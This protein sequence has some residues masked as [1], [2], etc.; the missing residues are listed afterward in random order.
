MII[1]KFP[2]FNF[3][4]AGIFCFV[5]MFIIQGTEKKKNEPQNLVRKVE[6]I[7]NEKQVYA[8]EILHLQTS[9]IEKGTSVL[10]FIKDSLFFWSDNSASIPSDFTQ[11]KVSEEPV[12]LRLKNGWYMVQGKKSGNYSMYV[13]ILIRQEYPFENDY[14]KNAFPEYFGLPQSTEVTTEKA[15]FPVYLP[16][17]KYA[18]NLSFP[19][20]CRSTS[21]ISTII[22]ILFLLSYLFLTAFLYRFYKNI[23]KRFTWKYFLLFGITLDLLFLRGLQFYLAFPSFLYQSDLFGP[24]FYSSSFLLPSL[25]D[26]L[27]NSTLLLALACIYYLEWPD[28]KHEKMSNGRNRL[29][30]PFLTSL[31]ALAALAGAVFF[32]REFIINSVIPLNLQDISSLIPYSG[33][34][35]FIIWTL[36]TSILLFFWKPLNRAIPGRIIRIKPTINIRISLVA[37]IV[38]SFISMLIINHANNYKEKEKRKILAIKLATK[39]NPITEIIFS[40]MEKKILTD[41]TVIR[42]AHEAGTGQRG[43]QF[44][45]NYLKTFYFTN[46]WNK[47]NIQITQCTENKRLQVQ[48]Q[49]Y[50]I[51]CL[52][53]FQNIIKEFGEN[54]SSKNLHFLDYGY[55]KENYLAVIQLKPDHPDMKNGITSIFIELNSKY[56]FKDLGYPELLIDRKLIE[57]PDISEY[58]YAF[59]QNGNMQYCA[60][61]FPYNHSLRLFENSMTKGPFFNYSGANHYYYPLSKSTVLI[62]SRKQPNLLTT[63]SPFAYLFLFF[64]LSSLILFF[65]L[66]HSF[67]KAISIKTLRDRLQISIIGMLFLSFLVLGLVIVVY[68]IRL[69][70]EKNDDYLRERA[71]SVQV[72]LQYKFGSADNGFL[73]N[74]SVLE[75]QLIKMSNI[76]FSDIN[77]Y[78][79]TGTLI[80]SSRP[81]VFD[82]GL[83]SDRM[84]AEAFNQLKSGGQ[85]LYIHEEK[86]GEHYYSSAYLPF[87]NN[88]NELQ[89]FVNLPYFTRQDDLKKEISTFLVAF[90]NIYV[91]LFILGVFIAFIVAKYIASPLRLLAIK[92]AD[93]KLGMPNER[94]EW[95]RKDEIGQ[96]VSQYN[97]MVAE[98]GE[99]A[100][101]LAASEREGAWREMARQV[102][103]E[104]KNPL[105]PM[106]L[107]VQHL[108]RAWSDSAPGWDMRLDR[109]TRTITE[110]IDALATIATEFSDFAKMPLPQNEKLNLAEV[111][112]SIIFLYKDITRF[113]VDISIQEAFIWADRKQLLR[114]FTNL[115]NNAIEA[116]AGNPDGRIHVTLEKGNGN[117]FIKI[118]DN[119]KGIPVEQTE[120]VFQPNFT[121]KSGGMGLGLAIVKAILKGVDGTIRVES[122][123]GKGATFIIGIAMFQDGINIE[124]KDE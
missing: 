41:T 104:I 20:N 30:Y 3:L 9:R 61:K 99:S 12:F 62:I 16:D 105:T 124:S 27:I 91:L 89:G 48:P 18:F 79:S 10:M 84:N 57:V 44:L 46:Y 114:V 86:I 50:L 101:K 13:F 109:F 60:G 54:T 49:G 47:F 32:I 45:E 40:Q 68:I 103:H 53:Y 39:R 8:R 1:R 22:L 69:N 23:S 29:L 90:I 11:Q 75:N 15:G 116:I 5:L 107:S 94:I 95:Q 113:S 2:G 64:G 67:Y 14:L 122:E 115:F 26:L 4:L 85:S 121:T 77:I 118:Q 74:V 70:N 42:L 106:K 102:A 55:G 108:Q 76:F 43:D 87:F 80:A 111:L 92:M 63:I 112:H 82:E 96:L 65:I 97:N 52:D 6:R 21:G 35:I 123:E 38:F 117:Y 72:E 24:A 25:G 66:R 110:Q 17:G 59:F 31:I 28:P 71:L 81:Q 33:Y 83:I 19:K 73:E 93:F 58:S 37:I 78:T 120:S 100:E 36:W 56:V 119:G 88:R 7:L 98:L 34:G 51:N